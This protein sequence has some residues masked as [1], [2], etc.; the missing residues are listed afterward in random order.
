[1]IQVIAFGI[2]Q[3]LVSVVEQVLE[4]ENGEFLV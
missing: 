3:P 1:M 2:Q 4:E